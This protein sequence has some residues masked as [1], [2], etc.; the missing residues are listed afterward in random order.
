MYATC[1]FPLL[2]SFFF[3]PRFTGQ[4]GRKGSRIERRNSS[5][6]E[7][8]RNNSNLR[9]GSRTAA[10][11]QR[12]TR[13]QRLANAVPFHRVRPPPTRPPL[14][15]TH[16]PRIGRTNKWSTDNPTLRVYAQIILPVRATCYRFPRSEACLLHFDRSLRFRRTSAS[17]TSERDGEARATPLRFP[18]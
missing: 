13:A 9:T 17:R 4:P 6:A 7:H 3:S 12:L 10:N 16:L 11:F 15:L 5:T 1:V 8:E 18:L 2:F 14:P